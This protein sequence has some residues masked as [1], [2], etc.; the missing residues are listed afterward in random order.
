MRINIFYSLLYQIV[1]IISPLI[2][3]PYISRILGPQNI[4]IYS[5]SYSIAYYFFLFAMLGVNDYG[6][7][8]IA[9]VRNDKHKLSDTFCQIYYIQCFCGVIFSILY[10]IYIQSVSNNHNIF[11]IQLLYVLSS[12]VDVTWFA[13]GMEKFKITSIRNCIVKIISVILIFTFVK[14][15][16]DLPIYC[17]IM[18]GGIIVS[19]FLVWPIVFKNVKFVPPN[20]KKILFHFKKNI[21][22]FIPL[23]ATS[24]YQGMDKIM[25]ANLVNEKQVGF[26]TYAENILNIPMGILTAIN[27]VLM[28]KIAHLTIK[29][30]NS[31][32]QIINLSIK[33]TS[34]IMILLSFGIFAIA[35]IFIPWYLGSNYIATSVLLQILSPVILLNGWDNLLRTTYLMPN[36]KDKVYVTSVVISSLINFFLNLIFISKI[37]AIGACLATVVA[38]IATLVIQSVYIRKEFKFYKYIINSIPFILIGFAMVCLINLIP[39]FESI[40]LTLLLKM[41]SGGCFFILLAFTYIKKIK[42]DYLT[43]AIL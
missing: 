37:G 40:I 14:N 23:V 35:P 11:L 7:R 43:Q 30:D 39:T 13:F 15:E 3:S 31:K 12:I 2:T 5:Y 25:I 1:V 32:D 29:G 33:L 6:N 20:I 18:S 19:Q 21:V 36:S 38:R 9:F 4:G 17:I 10:F 22:L 24:L 16:N 34:I 42:K 41:T 8:S 28:P 26:Y 27:T